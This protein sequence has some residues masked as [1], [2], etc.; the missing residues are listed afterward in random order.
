MDQILQN[1]TK[2]A[3]IT[4]I[5]KKILKTSQCARDRRPPRSETPRC[6]RAK[7]K[8]GSLW[9]QPRTHKKFV[10]LRIVLIKFG[11]FCKIW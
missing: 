9:S 2:L 6:G 4:K 11:D 10:I 5:L 7:S 1:S 3:Q 8:P